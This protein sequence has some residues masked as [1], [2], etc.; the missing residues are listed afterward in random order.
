[1]HLL[2]NLRLIVV[3]FHFGESCLGDVHTQHLYALSSGGKHNPKRLRVHS[4]VHVELVDI[5]RRHECFEA[6]MGVCRV[7]QQRWMYPSLSALRSTAENSFTA[8]YSV[9]SLSLSSTVLTLL[10]CGIRARYLITPLTPN[11]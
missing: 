1:M 9:L 11:E 5:Q 8:S 7:Q 3:P 6:R 4:S 2:Q 10:H